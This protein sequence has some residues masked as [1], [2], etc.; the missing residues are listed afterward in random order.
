M[1]RD[2]AR[3]VERV[4]GD[5]PRPL[6]AQPRQVDAARPGGYAIYKRRHK[7]FFYP[8]RLW[9]ALAL[10]LWI[11]VLI[12]LFFINMVRWTSSALTAAQEF[13]A[14]MSVEAQHH[15]AIGEVT[16]Y[17]PTF[18]VV[19]L[20]LW[21]FLADAGR[22]AIVHAALIGTGLGVPLVQSGI[23]LFN[24]YHVFVLY[25]GRMMKLRRGEYF[26][27]RNIYRE[28]YASLYIGY[29]VAGMTLSGAFFIGAGVC[30]RC[31]SPPHHRRHDRWAAA[32][33]SRAGAAT[34]RRSLW[35]LARSPSR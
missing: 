24:W 26:F 13:D 20:T 17:A 10:S 22:G 27:D 4:G 18:R 32:R 21:A 6:G 2:V 33:T 1:D 7:S 5:A 35:T 16:R 23:L 30:S 25:R 29:Q 31:P 15:A 8:Q 14:K 3:L 9:M 34:A 12:T 28:E 11:Q 19:M